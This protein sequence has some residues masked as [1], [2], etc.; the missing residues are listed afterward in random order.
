[1]NKHDFNDALACIEEEIKYNVKTCNM[2][3]DKCVTKDIRLVAHRIIEHDGEIKIE[4]DSL[5]RYNYL[6]S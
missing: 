6:Q 2:L 5:H 3:L 4:S 1:M